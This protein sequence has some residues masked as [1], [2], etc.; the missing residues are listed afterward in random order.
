[1]AKLVEL[2]SQTVARIGI[3]VP[4]TVR[5]NL[6]LLE[7]EINVTWA[8]LRI[9]LNRPCKKNILVSISEVFTNGKFETT[10]Y[11]RTKNL[12]LT[13]RM[14]P[15]INNSDII[16]T[17]H[18][19]LAF[20]SER[21]EEDNY[22]DEKLIILPTFREKRTPKPI[23]IELQGIVLSIK[24]DTYKEEE[25]VEIDYQL[26][27]FKNLEINLVQESKV[28]CK[29]EDY[30]TCVYI[31]PDKDKIVTLKTEIIKNPLS[32]GKVT[33][34][35]PKGLDESQDYSWDDASK[36]KI[37]H[38]LKYSNSYYLKVN[39]INSNDE[40]IK[41]Q[42]PIVITK[43]QE[44]MELFT[45]ST[46]EPF[47]FISSPDLIKLIEKKVEGSKTYFTLKNTSKNNFEGV[48]VKLT[49][50]KEMFFELP[51][52]MIGKKVWNSGE[53]LVISIAETS[54]NIEYQVMIEDNNGIEIVKK[55]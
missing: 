26:E 4:V 29:C 28:N 20:K 9:Y 53:D 23:K 43:D 55:I 14:I 6:D 10:K 3:P 18:G 17:I 51:P 37:L 44:E 46:K 21:G 40:I 2:E 27:N 25:E 45:K 33:I 47:K 13:R 31:K 36:S 34:K 1:M 15:T 24:K 42:T 12:Q 35:L 54:S 50:I 19:S 5:Y 11:K 49:G 22:D 16:Y 38:L 8:G 39:A 7:N 48:T 30:K 52:L 41:F 32:T